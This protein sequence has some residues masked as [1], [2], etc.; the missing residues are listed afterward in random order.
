M[1]K[2]VIIWAVSLCVVLAGPRPGRA[3]PPDKP[4]KDV[5]IPGVELDKLTPS[6]RANLVRLVE[7]YPSA[8]GK[9]HSLLT[10]LKTDPK[11]RRSVI[12]VQTLRKWLLDGLLPSEVEERYEARF[13]N[14]K[15]YEIDTTGAPVRGDPKAPVA[16]VEFSDFQC[17]ACKAA[18]PLLLRILREIPQAKLVFMN[19]PLPMHQNAV[20]AA[21]A[22]IAAGKQGKF[23]AY[24]DKLY[25]NQERLGPTDLLRYAQEL[26]LDLGRFQADMEGARVRVARDKALGEK[27]EIDSTPT[28]FING[29][30]YTDSK[31]FEALK[32]WIDEELVR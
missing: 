31:T 5:L 1:N 26:K 25:E 2:H 16:I 3:G 20:P 18:E 13:L 14:K 4:D 10:S 23:W 30:K 19:Y 9:P 12:A 17:P 11:C 29:R 22:A 8:C 7:K 15:V 28:I 6:E 27:L 24:H 32:S 21:A